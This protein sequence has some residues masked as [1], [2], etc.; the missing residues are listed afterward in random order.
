[1]IALIIYLMGS[2]GNLGFQI[3]LVA[4]A[5][6]GR[7]TQGGQHEGALPRSG[8]IIAC[9]S[10]FVVVGMA[11]AIASSAGLWPHWSQWTGWVALAIHAL[12]AVLNWITPS[13]AERMLWGPITLALLV[14]ASVVVFTAP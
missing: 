7:I 13:R 1:M 3:A 14:F 6:W 10:I 12:S 5:P 11:G 8:R 4:G 2:V 9:A